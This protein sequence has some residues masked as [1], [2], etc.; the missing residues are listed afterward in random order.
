[1]KRLFDAVFSLRYVAVLAVIGPFFRAVLM[2][3]FGTQNT[4]EAYLLYFGLMNQKGD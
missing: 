3:L 1:M 4:I 2:L